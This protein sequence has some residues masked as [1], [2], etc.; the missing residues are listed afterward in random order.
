MDVLHALGAERPPLTRLARLPYY[1][2]LVVATVCVGAFLGQLDASIASLVLPTLEEVFR[3][4]VA[5]VEWVAISYLLTLA[6]LLVPLGRLADLTGRKALYTGGFVLFIL[7]SGL[8]GLAPRL[9]WLIACRV[10]QALGAAMLQAN[11]VAIIASAVG[12]RELGRAIGIQG[13]AQ[14]T[15]L[16][17]GPSVGGLLIAA[18]G[19]QWVFFIAVPFG[20]AGAV[21]GWLVL[22]CT[23]RAP[24]AIQCAERFDW[25]G[26]VLF[27]PLVAL[28]VLVLT[29]GPVW[30][31]TSPRLLASAGCALALLLAFA[32]QEQRTP[33]PLIDVA[34]FRNRLFATAILA[35]LLAY[36]VLFGAL[37]LLPFYLER[38]LGYGPSGTGLLL[39]P[40]SIALGLVA[41]LAGLATDRVGAPGPTIAGLLTTALALAGLGLAPSA[42]GPVVL[43]LA[44]LG[45]GVGTFLPANNSVIMASAPASRRGVAAGLLNMARSLGTSLGVAA[46]GTLLTLR[47]AA[48]VG[49]PVASTIEVPVADLGPAFREVFG[50]LAA[51]AIITALLA[52]ARGATLPATQRASATPRE[53][54]TSEAVGARESEWL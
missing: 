14:A 22:P 47:L 38:L 37:F 34:L 7:G 32:L 13:A 33:W 20:A 54:G 25:L 10:L 31:W 41:P 42:V 40:V 39:T 53:P 46:A 5:S 4:P 6:A 43:L 49:H 51:L 23:A 12:P 28:S 52:V 45:L 26:A 35:G 18:L 44:L 24:A 9:E 15:G 17:L 29:F 19:W 8:C 36:G 27:G 30:G 1:R 16:A 3:A 21:L 50:A 11:S 48:R 2:W